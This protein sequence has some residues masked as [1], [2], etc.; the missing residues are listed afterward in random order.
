MSRR[1]PED[2]IV[3]SGVGAV[4]ATGHSAAVSFTSVKAGLARIGESAELFI[5]DDK[6]KRLAV[7]C[8][9]VEGVADGHRRFLRLYRLA[10]RAFAEAT[11]HA[12]FDATMLEST[13]MY[14]ALAEANRPGL[15]DRAESRLAA[16]L[17]QALEI[18]DMSAQTTIVAAGHA[19][20][21][22]A[23]DAAVQAIRRGERT[24]VIVGAVDTYLDELSLQWLHDIGRLK[25]AGSAKGFVPGEAAAF[26]VI[27]RKAAAEERGAGCYAAL[28]SVATGH[29][30]NGYY[31][32]DVPCTGEGLTQAIRSALGG[33]IGP[34]AVSLVLCDLN[35]ERHRANE[36]G[37]AMARCFGS[38]AGPSMLWHPADGL[39][40]VGA[41]SGVLNLV[42]G[43]LALARS[44]RGRSALA[45]GASDDGERGA[46]VLS[47]LS[48]RAPAREAPSWA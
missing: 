9:A 16:R 32:R 6:Q 7:N 3:V 47:A 11:A 44:P 31:E 15:D 22:I 4:C 33:R 17:S 8:A 1:T 48:S 36:W 5:R 45:W 43:T 25:L 10:V 20:G 24:R 35:G 13:P 46:A 2:S 12:R 18:A 27:E 29:E 40:D 14:L 39:G 34:A 23:L 28:E 21:F 30:A 38:D 42:L 37:L 19:G 41:A 26:L